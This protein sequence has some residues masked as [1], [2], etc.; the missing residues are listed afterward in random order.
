MVEVL[1]EAMRTIEPGQTG[2]IVGHGAALRI[3]LLALFDVPQHAREMLGGM[4]NCAWAVLEEHR[5]RGWQIVDYNAQT[6]P[7]PLELADDLQT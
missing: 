3:G 1:T 2:I 5:D 4:A 6:L 7:P